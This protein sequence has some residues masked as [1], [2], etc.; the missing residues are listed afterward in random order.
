MAG[1]FAVGTMAAVAVFFLIAG[2]SKGYAGEVEGIKTE[3]LTSSGSESGILTYRLSQRQIR[4]WKVIQ[5][6]VLARDVAGFPAHPVLYNLWRR[7]QESGCSIEIEF[8]DSGRAK[9]NLVG[10]FLIDAASS[11]RGVLSGII[12]LNLAI[13]DRGSVSSRIRGQRAGFKGLI[14][15]ERYAQVLGHELAHVVL[16]LEDAAY[17]AKLRE[18]D[19]AVKSFLSFRRQ[20]GKDFGSRDEERRFLSRIDS[21]G[22]E[23]EGPANEIESNVWHELRISSGSGRRK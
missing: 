17:Q 22:I 5:S 23:M 6:V 8:I 12:Q 18:L 7:V 1:R 13:I 19:Q 4:T 9:I 11:E 15:V 14:R 3:K 10:Q 21:L 2:G 20:G 16:A